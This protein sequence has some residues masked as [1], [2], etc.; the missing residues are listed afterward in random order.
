MDKIFGISLDELYWNLKIGKSKRRTNIFEMRN[1]LSER[2][3]DPVF[4]LS[5]GRCGTKWFSELLDNNGNCV[6]HSPIP[7]FALQNRIVYDVLNSENQD[8]TKFELIKE[9]FLTG[10]EQHLRFCYKAEKRYIETNNYITFFAPILAKIFPEAKFVHLYRHP[11]E[12]VRSGVRRGYFAKE[13]PDDLKRPIPTQ[14]GGAMLT[15]QIQKVSW[16]WNAT[17]QFVEDFKTGRAERCFSFNFNELNEQNVNN[18]MEFL[19]IEL[20]NGL[21]NKQLRRKVN[22]QTKGN[23]KNYHDWNKSE[24]ADLQLICG[25]LASKYK[26]KL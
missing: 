23:Y 15:S 13:N 17:N 7:S 26:Y 8:N 14:D 25:A 16:L 4:F 24:K 3:K 21:L 19:N 18:L 12:F 22:V 20:P 2:V 11:G 10:R 9:I 1:E 5:T 6:L